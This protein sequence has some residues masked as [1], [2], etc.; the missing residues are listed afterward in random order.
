MT[1][2]NRPLLCACSIALTTFFNVF[3]GHDAAR[4]VLALLKHFRQFKE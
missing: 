2:V 3:F 1:G 4:H